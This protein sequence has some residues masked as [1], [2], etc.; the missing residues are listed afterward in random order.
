M[1][2]DDRLRNMQHIIFITHLTHLGTLWVP[3]ASWR[4]EAA[5]RQV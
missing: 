2:N 3:A 5:S 1:T 4:L